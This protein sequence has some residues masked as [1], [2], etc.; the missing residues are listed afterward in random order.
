MS[1]EDPE[2]STIVVLTPGPFNSAYFE[3]TF[4]ARTMGHRAGRGLPTCSSSDDEVFVRTTHG[5]R[6]VH[7][8][9]R[10][11]DDAYLDPEFFRPDSM[12]GVPGLMRA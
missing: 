8:I 1:P 4:L 9:Y 3:H 11:I 2:K 7:V 12:L 6:R 10:R 5:P